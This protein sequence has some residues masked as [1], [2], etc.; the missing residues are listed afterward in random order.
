MA[1]QTVDAGVVTLA[2]AE[3]DVFDVSTKADVPQLRKHAVGTP[4]VLDKSRGL[5]R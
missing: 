3:A 5:R 4:D 2:Q 1:D